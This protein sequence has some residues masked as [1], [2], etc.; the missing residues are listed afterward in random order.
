MRFGVDKFASNALY[1][2]TALPVEN[3]GDVF[4]LEFHSWDTDLGALN[5]EEY[6]RLTAQLVSRV[7]NGWT[8]DDQS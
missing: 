5:T 4:A 7:P 8:P 1:K 3:G 2:G 6:V